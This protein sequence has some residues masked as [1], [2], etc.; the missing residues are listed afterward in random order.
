MYEAFGLHRALCRMGSGGGTDTAGVS[1]DDG[2]DNIGFS[3]NHNGRSKN[4]NPLENSRNGGAGIEKTKRN[5]AVITM[6]REPAQPALLA[7]AKPFLACAHDT[8][9]AF[10]RAYPEMV[11]PDGGGGGGGGNTVFAAGARNVLV[12]AKAVYEMQCVVDMLLF[13]NFAS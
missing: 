2:K 1:V 7:A 9:A 3:T 10:A 13:W 8:V 4:D 12:Q 6:L 5:T 11:P